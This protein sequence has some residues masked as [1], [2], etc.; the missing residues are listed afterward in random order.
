MQQLMQ[1]NDIFS[2]AFFMSKK[3]HTLY[4]IHILVHNN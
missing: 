4:I 3:Q 1:F 2:F